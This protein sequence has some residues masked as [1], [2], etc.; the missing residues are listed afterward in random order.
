MQH[1]G[2][3]SGQSQKKKQKRKMKLINFMKPGKS[4]E[5]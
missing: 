5:K 2:R 4:K 3:F 1:Y